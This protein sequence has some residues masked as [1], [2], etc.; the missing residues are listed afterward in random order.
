MQEYKTLISTEQTFHLLN[1]PNIAI[2]DCRYNLFDP[3][4][5]KAEYQTSHIPGAI[6]AHLK[7]DLAGPVIPGNTGRHPLPDID[8]FSK[9]LSL[10]GIGPETQV[11]AYDD[12]NLAIAARVWWLLKWLGH[13]NVAVLDGGFEKWV[14]ENLPTTDEIPTT[15]PNKFVPHPQKDMLVTSKEMEQLIKGK[16][17]LIID[18]RAEERYRGITE[19][20]DPVAGHIPGAINYFYKENNLP[21]GEFKPS[22]TLSKD[23]KKI[24]NGYP[25]EN[26]IFYCGSG[27]T[28]AHN[29]LAYYHVGLGL[30]KLYAG[31]WSEWITDLKR[32]ITTKERE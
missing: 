10:W 20:I 6:Y 9:K 30:P 22:D 18:S 21:N 28:G 27:V 29:I 7:Y 5:G 19:P 14:N 1:N 16:E 23:F 12:I 11:I 32:P 26:T 3:N 24:T 17:F 31:S 15:Q 4:K 25:A 13:D 8:A 2:I